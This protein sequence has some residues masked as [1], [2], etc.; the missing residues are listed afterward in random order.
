MAVKRS[1]AEW[2]EISIAAEASAAVYGCLGPTEARELVPAAWNGTTKTMTLETRSLDGN[3]TLVVAV[4]GSATMMDWAVN[5][6]S[7]PAD[8]PE[9]RF[10]VRQHVLLITWPS[11]G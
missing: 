8:A 7:E 2:H 9:V 5:A 6:N 4:R 10:S 3:N 11:A 1:T